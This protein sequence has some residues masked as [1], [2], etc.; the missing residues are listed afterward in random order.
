MRRCGFLDT[1]LL[2]H[3]HETEFSSR[4]ENSERGLKKVGQKLMLV[5]RVLVERCVPNYADTDTY[6]FW[7]RN[8]EWDYF[9]SRQKTAA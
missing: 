5:S 4:R 2:L 7:T 6:T 8:E 9:S 3:E 1:A